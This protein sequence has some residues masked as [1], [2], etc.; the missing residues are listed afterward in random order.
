MD[1]GAWWATFLRV[2]KSRTRLKQ[3]SKHRGHMVHRSQSQNLTLSGSCTLLPTPSPVC[4]YRNRLLCLTAG[5]RM[6]P[7]SA[8]DTQDCSRLVFPWLC[9]GKPNCCN[10]VIKLSLYPRKWARA[11]SCLFLWLSQIIKWAAASK[12]VCSHLIQWLR[13]LAYSQLPTPSPGLQ[14]SSNGT[15]KV[16]LSWQ[17]K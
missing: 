2:A 3:L 4:L 14:D 11:T 10:C 9:L 13:V 7:D 8:D 1:S 6:Q 12:H 17:F 15:L 16:N 5:V